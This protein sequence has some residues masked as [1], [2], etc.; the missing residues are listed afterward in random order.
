MPDPDAEAPDPTD[1][2]AAL[3]ADLAAAYVRGRRPDLAALK[4]ADLLAA[5]R[6]AGL[7][8]HRFKRT[9][10]LPRVKAVLG[11]L[12]AFAPE[13]LLDIGPGRG[14]FLWP[15][16]D[17]FPRLAVTVIEQDPRRLEHLAAV[18][19]GGVERLTPIA[20]DAAE[21]RPERFDVVTALEVLEHQRD[22]V[23]M[24]RA[25]VAA[26][27][28]AVIASAPS[29]PDD[30]PEHVQLFTGESLSALLTEAGAARVTIT[31]V[32]GHIIAVARAPEAP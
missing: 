6:A 7:K 1:A 27:R 2:A 12:H 21:P 3:Y 18:A 13:T 11:A 23:P 32:R 30:N 5:G 19:A 10:G 14:V 31:Y 16:L 22:P 8:L 28:R 24:A 15:L 26:A 20:G 25:A 4:D 9:M 29:K 17:A